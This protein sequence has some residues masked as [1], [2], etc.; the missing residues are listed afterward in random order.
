M[1]PRIES[2]HQEGGRR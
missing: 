2:R 1:C